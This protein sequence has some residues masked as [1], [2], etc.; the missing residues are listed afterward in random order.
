MAR[1]D[2]EQFDRCRSI[3]EYSVT[4]SSIDFVDLCSAKPSPDF[5][6]NDVRLDPWANALSNISGS[7]D[8]AQQH[9]L[10]SYLLARAFGYR[11]H[12]QNELIE[13]AFDEVYF[14]ALHERLA[15]DA[16]QLL[17]RSLPRSWFRLGLLS[18][19][20]KLCNGHV[21]E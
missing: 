18:A 14:A 12:S 20:A 6:P 7:L 21:C 16:R 17:D 4:N 10:C 13:Y 3:P 15:S 1:S 2:S 9:Y 11:S 5:I 19:S 8:D